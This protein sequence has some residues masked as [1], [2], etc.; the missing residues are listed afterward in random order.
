MWVLSFLM[1]GLVSINLDQKRIR[2]TKINNQYKLVNG[3]TK[4][5]YTFILK[6]PINS[7]IEFNSH[8][9]LA[10][11]ISFNDLAGRQLDLLLDVYLN[12]RR[13]NSNLEKYT[14]EK[15]LLPVY[16]E[17][18]EKMK[19]SLGKGHISVKNKEIFFILSVYYLE[20]F[21]KIR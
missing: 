5:Y 16:S 2:K 1:I 20:N 12:I 18:G 13:N 9:C 8:S 6:L 4:S 19:L 7:E 14:L 3:R 17:V 21:Q 10:R 11:R 15:L